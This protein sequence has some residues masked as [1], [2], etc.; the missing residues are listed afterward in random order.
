MTDKTPPETVLCSAHRC[1]ME[2]MNN[3]LYI[4]KALSNVT[5]RLKLTKNPRRSYL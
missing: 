3:M 2:V 4:R 1:A 5:H